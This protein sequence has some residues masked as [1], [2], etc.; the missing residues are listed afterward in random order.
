MEGDT[1][2][3][4][5]FTARRFGRLACGAKEKQNKKLQ[6]HIIFHLYPSVADPL[7]WARYSL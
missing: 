1:E 3:I 6:G 5:Y 2:N 4:S 7:V